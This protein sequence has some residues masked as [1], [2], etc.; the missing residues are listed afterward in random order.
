MI[1][2]RRVMVH[3]VT[4]H[5][6]SLTAMATTVLEET[7]DSPDMLARWEGDAGQVEAST[8]V[9]RTS[10]AKS[11][12]NRRLVIKGDK[13][14]GRLITVS[15]RVRSTNV[16]EPPRHWNGV[17]VML[18]LELDEGMQY[19]QLDIPGGTFEWRDFSRTM[20]IPSGVRKATLVLGLE[21]VAGEVAF[22]DVS[23]QLGRPTRGGER[24][25]EKFK[26]HDLPRLRGVMHGP[27]FDEEDI[28]HL[29][30]EWGANQVRWQLNWTP[31]KRAEVWARDLDDYDTWLEGALEECDKALDAC[32]KHGIRVLVD[33]HTPPGGRVEGG[34]CP[35][36]SRTDCQRR[37]LDT[38]SL[39]ATRYKGH[40][41]V[42]AYD[43]LNEPVEP[44]GGGDIT[45]HDLATKTIRL[46]REID[47]D[48]PIVY[49]PGPWGSP[50]GFDLQIPLDLDHV[51]YSFHMYKPHNFTHQTLH[52]SPGGTVYPGMVD[53]E[54][55][56]KE[57]LRE[58]MRPAIEFQ[59]EFNVHM[60]V[61]E[62][63]AIRWA[64]G[65][66]AYRYL[67]DLIDLFEEYGWDWSYHAYREFHG[68][69]AEHTTHQADIKHSATPTPREHLLV[70]WFGKNRR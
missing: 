5:L 29:A 68:W 7:F 40:T 1:S 55:W 3:L 19:P 28:R 22:D 53:G 36:F 21:A 61:G 33:L 20:R 37:F 48:R 67:R 2:E 25:A 14:A 50:D 23:V 70:E 31:M 43:L 49:E 11:S 15:A 57:R 69:S 59:E 66:S 8:L 26:G 10:D 9:I 35:L 34:V 58:A 51:I 62:F 27:H 38:W 60:Y 52:D 32:A 46:I 12:A 63:S 47:P 16:T 64:P 17:K 30:Q 54:L 39:I 13:I 65:N 6:V 44:K 24:Q 4:V 41:A 42:Y 45:W 18:T 56:D